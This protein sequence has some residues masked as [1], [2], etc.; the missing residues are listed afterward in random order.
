MDMFES[1]RSPGEDTPV[2]GRFSGFGLLNEKSMI[3]FNP[4]EALD[5]KISAL[6]CSSNINKGE[7]SENPAKKIS[8]S[9][10]ISNGQ[11]IFSEG[12]DIHVICPEICSNSSSKVFG[13]GLFHGDSS[14][15]KAAI[16]QGVMSDSGRVIVRVQSSGEKYD[17]NLQNGIRS[18]NKE[19]DG[20][21]A[22]IVV[23]YAPECPYQVNDKEFSSFIEQSTEINE[24][25]NDSLFNQNEDKTQELIDSLINNNKQKTQ[26]LNSNSIRFAQKS[27][28]KKNKKQF[29][30]SFGADV[31]GLTSKAAS[32]ASDALGLLNGFG[33][34]ANG[35]AAASLG[36]GGNLGANGGFGASGGISGALNALGSLGLG[37][38]AGGSIGGNANAN[39]YGG[40]QGAAG[41][42]GSAGA[43]LSSQPITPNDM[44]SNLSLGIGTGGTF[45][46]GNTQSAGQNSISNPSSSIN[47]NGNFGGPNPYDNISAA[48]SKP[49]TPS[50]PNLA[51]SVPA[52]G[53]NA[54]MNL[55]SDGKNPSTGSSSAN[56]S[57]PEAYQVPDKH[58]GDGAL[59]AGIDMGASKLD[60]SNTG[61]K[62]VD[63]L[64]DSDSGNSADEGDSD[65]IDTSSHSVTDLIASGIEVETSMS[66]GLEL[67]SLYDSS[68]RSFMRGLKEKS[69]KIAITVKAFGSAL[70]H[71]IGA[72]GSG[73]M[74]ASEMNKDLNLNNEGNLE[75]TSTSSFSISIT[76]KFSPSIK[77]GSNCS[78]A[79]MPGQL[80]KMAENKEKM[81]VKE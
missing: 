53:M 45:N 68:I 25:H 31:S 62:N 63:P 7:Y 19:N 22:F 54:N 40:M 59:K 38:S 76:K 72:T 74:K 34:S 13:N 69:G 1:V 43:S 49:Q 21:P 4:H 67:D 47:I 77:I 71:A 28:E 79:N 50:D 56:S 81:K 8:C 15:C 35:S 14:I 30:G 6:I 55:A 3:T 52:T 10:N 32:A 11:D 36:L 51:S 65:S 46:L 5:V 26:S 9:T 23:K 57:S 17:G 2:N 66:A 64:A 75:S 44:A 48:F 41:G 12:R 42:S 58:L 39:Y 27:S 60:L 20:L 33:G 37:G 24:L 16:H 78:I 73:N 70:N 61:K 18:E 29:N 80:R